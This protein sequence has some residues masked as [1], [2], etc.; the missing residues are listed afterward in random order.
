LEFG[1]QLHLLEFATELSSNAHF[2]T[3]NVTG[4]LP[5]HSNPADRFSLQSGFIG[6]PIVSA[7][8]QLQFDPSYSPVFKLLD[9]IED[10]E[11]DDVIV[12]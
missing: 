7:A 10:E 11:I 6:G 3:F 4:R 5:E 1:T 12:D 8:T 2:A 9:E